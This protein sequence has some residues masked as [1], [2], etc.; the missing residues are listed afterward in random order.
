MIP[1]KNTPGKNNLAEKYGSFSLFDPEHFIRRV[2]KNWYWFVLMGLLGYGIYYIYNKYYAQR[3]Y[4]SS[5]SLSISKNTASYFTPSQ[6]IN[7]IWGQDSNRDGVY[8]KKMILS[9]SHN[10]YLVN[11]LDLFVNYATKG[12]IKQ[13]YLDKYDSPVFLVIDRNHL[14]QVNFPITLIPKGANTYEVQLPEEGRSTNLYNYNTEAF[15]RINTYAQPKKTNISVGQWYTAP[16]FRFKLVK[17]PV[18][19]SIELDNIIITLSTVN[20]AVN[21]IVNNIAVDFDKELPTIMIITKR[22]YN[23]NGTVQFLNTTVDELIKKRL[24]DQNVVDKNTSEYLAENLK[25]IRKKLDSA[26]QKLNQ[27]KITEGL[28]DVE[29]KDAKT[30]EKI[31]TLEAKRADLL[32]KVNSLNAVR[33]SL[34]T[35][36]LDRMISLNAAGIEDGMF[37]ATVSDLKSLYAKRR[38]LAQIYTPNSEP[39]R[40]IN[41]LINEASGNSQ[42]SLRRYYA[43]YYDEINKINREISAA[44]NQLIKLPEQQRRYFDV[45]RGYNIIESTYNALLT[46]QAETDMRVQTSRSDLQVIDPAKNTGQGPIAPN[47][48]RAKYTIIG[49]L[50]A[51]PLLF[52]IIGELLDNK[53]RNIRELLSATRIPLLGVIGRNNYENN[54]TVL[55]QPK[56]SIAEA[57]RGIRSNLRFLYNEDGTSKV[58]LV[59]SSVGGEGK[60]F[61]SINIASVLALSGKKTILL[62][63]DLRKPKI[64]GDFKI[65]NK[66]GISNFLT[67]EVSMEQIINETAVPSL[68]VATSGPIPPNPSELLMSQR[69]IDFI[70]QLRREYDFVILD[71]PP[72]GLVADSFELMKLAD[73]N[74]YVVRH[75]YTEKYMLK[76]ITEKYHKHEVENLGLVYNDYLVNQGYGYD[77]GYGYGYGYGYFDEDKNYEEPTLVKLRN[78]LSKIFNRNS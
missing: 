61:T 19:P 12:A 36:N 49:G 41:R 57:F 10:E 11:N 59:T 67:G 42:N 29:G 69:N 77:Y 43:G 53:V 65:N 14:Q 2:I 46:K 48:A 22:G 47:V 45:E 37:N 30:V 72:A 27:V 60:T 4:S 55:H 31:A 24:R 50:L 62:G 34:A 73:A 23:L 40:E 54:L 13:T 20:D 8:L 66:Y 3:I 75:E 35:A 17:N 76:M 38:E 56:S 7:F 21:N 9:R 5:L 58:I 6:S 33:N 52:L 74:V 63:M 44:E 32:T 25:A 28:F 15:E 71:S 18:K 1:D 51:L 70:N 68:H 26:S 64:F 39:M 78:W 16:N